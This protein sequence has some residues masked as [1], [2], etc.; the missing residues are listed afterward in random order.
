MTVK[1]K[2]RA[3]VLFVCLGN[4]CRS[5]AGEGVLRKLIEKRGVEE[6]IHV[7]SCGLGGW[8]V[9]QPADERMRKASAR[10][11]FHLV[12]VAQQFVVSMFEKFDYVLAADEAVLN[13]LFDLAGDNL[14]YKNC[15]H[16]MTEFSPAYQNEE[17]PD[18]YYGGEAGFE[19]VLDML[20]D[21]CNG[22]L[23]HILDN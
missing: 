15:I 23:D 10:R 6:L 2:P 9:G 14:E 18:P 5:P 13:E 3:R 11:N 7:E 21:S 19:L 12:G 17:V 16:Y 20:E 22:L 1:K 8:H 4:I